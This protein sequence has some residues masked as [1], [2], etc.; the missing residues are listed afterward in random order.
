MKLWLLTI[1][2][3]AGYDSYDAHVVRADD[4]KRA[5]LMCPSGDEGRTA[6]QDS[7]VTNCIELKEE[8]EMKV[9]ISSFNAG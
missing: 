6:W 1:K 4:E 3:G 2:E 8:G 9:I 5:R 7:N